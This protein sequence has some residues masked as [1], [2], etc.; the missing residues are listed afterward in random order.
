MAVT[1]RVHD[2]IDRVDAEQE[3]VA[4][5]LSA[6]DRFEA[7]VRD[8]DPVSP[9]ASAASSRTAG[10]AGLV[11]GAFQHSVAGPDRLDRVR[12]L[13][14]ETV[15]PYSLADVG[16]SEPLVETI[17]TE[18]GEEIATAVAPATRGRF[19]ADLKRAILSSVEQR[20]AE[21]RAMDRA[22]AREAE[23]LDAA[24]DAFESMADWLV[25]ADETPLSALGFEA[26]RER[27][28]VL[29]DYRARCEAV[30]RERQEVLHATTSYEGAA[31]LV[32]RSLAGY[33]Y[34]DLP[35][36]YPVL[37]TAVRFDA[38]CEACQ[39]AVRDHLTRRA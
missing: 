22:L 21:L 19:T 27:H 37:S 35:T 25:E 16:G 15:R 11:T 20:R 34:E 24:L 31:G 1:T 38:V 32:H 17:G 4:D 8:L 23:S 14:A 12:D 3:H 33:L 36:T 13:F 28:G 6:F 29:D 7:G 9:V 39:R 2:A 30:A 10:D 26:L 5:E 18:L